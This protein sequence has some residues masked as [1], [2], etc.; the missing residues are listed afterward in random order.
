GV[1]NYSGQ[2]DI[3]GG[4]A[5]AIGVDIDGDVSE[6]QLTISGLS[7][8][9]KQYDALTVAA[10]S[11]TGTLNG[12]VSGDVVNLNGTPTA[13]F[14]DKNVGTGKIVSILG[15]TISGSDAGNYTLLQPTATADITA[16]PL[17]FSGATANDK[18]YDGTTVA[19]VSGG[20]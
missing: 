14:S 18:V 9:N 5:P 6:K 19:T 3:T 15:F 16:K 8:A 10:I 20:A 11:G 13:N 17:S 12:V 7:S 4:C 1:G 2:I